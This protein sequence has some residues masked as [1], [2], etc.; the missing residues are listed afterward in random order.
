[1]QIVRGGK[2]LRFSRISLQSRMFSSEI[3]LSYYKVFLRFKMTESGQALVLPEDISNR[4]S[5][6][7]SS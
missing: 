2:L 1:M 6:S 4:V 7:I 5:A 3:F